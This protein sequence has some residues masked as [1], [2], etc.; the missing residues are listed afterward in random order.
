MG[1]SKGRLMA[2]RKI[3][4]LRLRTETILTHS[5]VSSTV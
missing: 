5:H 1:A 3:S 2:N 4:A